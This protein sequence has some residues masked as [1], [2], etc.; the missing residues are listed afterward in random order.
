MIAPLRTPVLGVA[1]FSGTG[2]TTLLG[3]VIPLLKARGLKLGL[4]KHSH[5]SFEIDKP[6]KDSYK[7]S[8]A[9]AVQTIIASRQRTVKIVNHAVHAEPTLADFLQRL[10]NERL[11]LIL[12]EGFKYQAIPKIE[13]H[14]P[15]LNKPLL[16][17][18]DAFVIAVATDTPLAL[19]VSVPLLELNNPAMIADFIQSV[20]IR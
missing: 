15:S 3:Q 5:H 14:R 19:Q 16:C 17:V 2:K 1:A 11:D 10:D 13:L 9:G 4:V 6:G 12:V 20:T 18:S 8:R 7:L